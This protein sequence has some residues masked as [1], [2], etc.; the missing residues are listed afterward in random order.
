MGYLHLYIMFCYQLLS[1]HILLEMKYGQYFY[2]GRINWIIVIYYSERERMRDIFY[3]SYIK[4]FVAN[5]FRVHVAPIL[6]Y[7][8]V[9]FQNYWIGV[10][11]TIYR[12]IKN[13]FVWKMTFVNYSW[14][15]KEHYKVRFQILRG[16]F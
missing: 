4:Y 2:L 10:V 3:L 5:L 7:L 1:L 16:N 11:L 12:Q 8:G 6:N 15:E 14:K 13:K 9:Q